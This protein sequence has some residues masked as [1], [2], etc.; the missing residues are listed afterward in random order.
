MIETP[1]E[2]LIRLQ[3]MA[4]VYGDYSAEGAAL[5]W[6]LESRKELLSSLRK[7]TRLLDPCADPVNPDT[8][9]QWRQEAN[10]AIAYAEEGTT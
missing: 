9:W 2:M 1:A 8:A 5:R 7:T 6:L 10:N 4:E 3:R